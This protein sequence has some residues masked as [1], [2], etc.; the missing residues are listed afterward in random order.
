[1]IGDVDIADLWVPYFCVS[2]NLTHARAEYHDRGP[3]VPAVRAS[4]AIPG[5]LP[6][7]PHHGDLL[8]DGG[9]LDNVPVEEMRR[10]NPTGTV[11]TVDVAPVEGP[12]AEH[13][14]GL[15]VSGFR[16]LFR[17]HKDGARPPSLVTTMVRSTIVAS[18]RDRQ[19]F[20]DEGI[21]DLYL[22]LQVD[23]GGMLDFSTAEQIA[24]GGAESCAARRSPSGSCRQARP[25]PA[26]C[27][28]ARRGPPSSTRSAGRARRRRAAPHAPRPPAPRRPLRV[29]RRRACRWSSRSSS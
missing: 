25:N 2:T 1:M 19:R 13:D 10:R 14:Y 27:A 17:R 3:L 26:T 8:V 12:M 9:V 5:V 29:G 18:V 22:D 24:D 6:P 7:V 28:R 21:A 20:V 15:S 11:I 4:I 16:S 23:G